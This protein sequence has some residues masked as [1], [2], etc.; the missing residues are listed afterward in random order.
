[1]AAECMSLH[2]AAGGDL[3]QTLAQRVG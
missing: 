1:M 3:A 2:E